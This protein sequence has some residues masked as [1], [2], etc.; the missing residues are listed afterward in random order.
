M[1]TCVALS[2]V[3]NNSIELHLNQ[4]IPELVG[5]PKRCAFLT[6]KIAKKSRKNILNANARYW[7]GKSECTE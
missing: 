3:P 7:K 4:N 5:L 1:Q 6:T 2:P